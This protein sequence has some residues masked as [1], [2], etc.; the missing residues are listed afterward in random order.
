MSIDATQVYLSLPHLPGYIDGVW[1]E[2][3]HL[4]LDQLSIGVDDDTKGPCPFICLRRKGS[5]EQIAIPTFE[6]DDHGNVLSVRLGSQFSVPPEE[7]WAMAQLE[8]AINAS[9]NHGESPLYA[10]MVTAEAWPN[11]VGVVVSEHEVIVDPTDLTNGLF[12]KPIFFESE[13][14]E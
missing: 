5:G 7:H 2:R 10:Y 4:T 8:H 9:R 11:S 1:C 14:V 3:I 6:F 13:V 12:G